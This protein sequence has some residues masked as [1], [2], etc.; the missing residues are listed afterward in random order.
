MGPF[1]RREA[2][3]LRTISVATNVRSQ[4]PDVHGINTARDVR[5]SPGGCE[6]RPPPGD[7]RNNRVRLG[8]LHNLPTR[9]RI[10]PVPKLRTDVR[11]KVPLRRI[12]RGFGGDLQ[13]MLR[14]G[15]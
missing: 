2:R 14:P 13:P 12:L 6:P 5:N 10:E 1:L 3:P 11:G 7:G 8:Q 4:G 9:A 15:L